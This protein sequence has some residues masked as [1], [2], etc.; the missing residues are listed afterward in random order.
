VAALI[1]SPSTFT[2]WDAEINF[3]IISAP[4]VD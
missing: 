4:I 3:E 1:R 2:L